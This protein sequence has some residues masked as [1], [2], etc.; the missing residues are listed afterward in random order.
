MRT[1]KLR[2]NG[3]ELEVPEGTSVL[4]AV[5]M[6]DQSAVRRSV[7]GEP[8]GPLCGMGICYECRLTVDG[9]EQVKSCQVPVREGMEVRTGG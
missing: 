1:V 6:A 5:L 3:Q 7:A 4:V 2:V 8:R 9:V